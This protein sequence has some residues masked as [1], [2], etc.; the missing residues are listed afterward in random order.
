MPIR[1]L[2]THDQDT[3]EVLVEG[4]AVW[5]GRKIVS[6][7]GRQWMQVNQDALAEIA[8]D[9]DLGTEAFRVFLYLSARL[10]FENLIVVPQAEIATALSMKR[11]A[12]GRALKLLAGKG[13]ILRGPKVGSVSS[14]QL[15][16]HYGWKGKV[17]NLH[18]ARQKP[19]RLVEVGKG[20]DEQ[21]GPGDVP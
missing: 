5:V 8:A 15:N 21:S 19:L 2:G 13:I 20:A 4:V 6:P 17:K 11:Q 1:R 9:R 14:Y 10:D 3:G 12:V 18:Q 16:P 7:Y